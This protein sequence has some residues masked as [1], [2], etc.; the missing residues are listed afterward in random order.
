VALWAHRPILHIRCPDFGDTD[1]GPHRFPLDTAP[2]CH[3]RSS[4]CRFSGHLGHSCP[5]YGGYPLSGDI[6]IL[7]I[8]PLSRA[9]RAEPGRR[10]IGDMASG[11]FSNLP[12]IGPISAQFGPILGTIIGPD[13]GPNMGPYWPN[14]AQCIGPL[15]GPKSCV[16]GPYS[17]A[18]PMVW[19]YLAQI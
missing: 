6:P 18:Q 19:A 11:H 9:F 15:S 7:P 14:K 5:R 3:T 1:F 2:P 16:L 8:W 13:H 10:F 17:K 4:R 12:L